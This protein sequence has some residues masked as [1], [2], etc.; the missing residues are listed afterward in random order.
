MKLKIRKLLFALSVNSRRKTKELAKFIRSSQQS[1]SYLINQ[2]KKKNYISD[3]MTVVDPIRLGF[4]NILVGFDFIK[5]EYAKKK[6]ILQVLSSHPNIVAIEENRQGVDLLVEYSVLNMSSF[7]KIHSEII[8]R[9]QGELAAKFIYPIIV[10][11][12]FHKNYLVRKG[13]FSDIIL[14]GDRDP[15]DL[16]GNERAVLYNITKNPEISVS[17]LAVKTGISTKTIVKIKQKL[18]KEEV[19]KGY[20]CILN[21]S[22]FEIH[23]YHIMFNFAYEGVRFI[24][25]FV[26]YARQHKNIV[27][28][29]KL[30]GH[31]QIIITVEELKPSDII[32]QIRTQ[33]PTD[34]YMVINSE[35]IIKKNTAPIEDLNPKTK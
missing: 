28:L 22:K 16:T 11:H 17:N 24:N 1:S 34:D 35:K 20:S 29:V 30:L 10:K 33:F 2:Y 26:Q 25:S 32:K 19:I 15:I 21:N 6:E 7:N 12:R 9:F 3:Y 8:G 27:S 13:D 5:L 23:R 18:E 31:Y 4:M 14:C